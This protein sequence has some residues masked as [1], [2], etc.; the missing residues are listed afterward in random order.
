MEF[1]LKYCTFPNENDR[2]DDV[3]AMIDYTTSS[4]NSESMIQSSVDDVQ[5][6]DGA[7]V[8][9][10]V[11]WILQLDAPGFTDSFQTTSPLLLTLSNA[12]CG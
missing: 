7:E 4:F 11:A 12:S 10:L 3:C 6:R 2:L 9:P 5:R 8:D 1:R